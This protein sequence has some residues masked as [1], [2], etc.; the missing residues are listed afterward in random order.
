MCVWARQISNEN[1]AKVKKIN[2]IRARPRDKSREP[3]TPNREY[4]RWKTLIAYFSNV[5]R[6]C[7]R[8]SFYQRRWLRRASEITRRRSNHREL[9]ILINPPRTVWSSYYLSECWNNSHTFRLQ[10]EC[11]ASALGFATC[12]LKNEKLRSR[13]QDCGALVTDIRTVIGTAFQ[14]CDGRMLMRW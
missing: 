3:Q 6:S 12:Q 9:H 4:S 11:K 1:N 5:D 7:P 8:R 13:G 10:R 14:S 2:N